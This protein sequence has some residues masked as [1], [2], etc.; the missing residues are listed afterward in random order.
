MQP[1]HSSISPSRIVFS[2][3]ALLALVGLFGFLLAWGIH[4]KLTWRDVIPPTF[5]ESAA[6]I[7][8]A[9]CIYYKQ[10]VLSVCSAPIIALGSITAL[11]RVCIAIVTVNGLPAGEG[12]IENMQTVAGAIAI[13]PI[14]ICSVLIYM[15][16]TS[17]QR[18]P[19]KLLL[20][21]IPV[22]CLLLVGCHFLLSTTVISR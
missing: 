3:R 19:V 16:I 11:D 6:C 5:M 22:V 21:P 20:L 9:T 8:I 13:A 15:L 17:N 2:L 18:R 12:S 10:T 7:W 14:L 1:S 4:F